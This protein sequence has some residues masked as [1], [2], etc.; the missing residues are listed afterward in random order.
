M[1]LISFFVIFIP[2][3]ILFSWMGIHF[4]K[5]F[6]RLDIVWFDAILGFIIGILKGFLWICIITLFVLNLS[7]LEFL[8]N[9]VYQSRFYQNFTYPIMVFI[10][11]MVQK[12]PEFSF[13]DVYLEKGIDQSDNELIKRYTEEF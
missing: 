7:F 6:T 2:V 10:D 9:G 13:L 12:I 1:N 4:R 8:N 3:V 5:V 11:S